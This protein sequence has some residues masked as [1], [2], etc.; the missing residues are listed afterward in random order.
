MP[1]IDDAMAPR[2]A[3]LTPWPWRLLALGLAAVA[4]LP[5]RHEFPPITDFAEH[6]ATIATLEDLWRH[7]PLE[8]WYQ[9]DFVHTQYWLM[10]VLGA[11]LAP[12][13]GGASAAL[14]LLMVAASAGLVASLLRLARNL[15][16]DERLVLVAVPL[17]WS[18]P[19]TLGFVPFVMA[20]PLVVLAL[21]ELASAPRPSTRQHGLIAVLSLATFFLN[22]ASVAWL[23]VAA[24][25]M[26]A[27]REVT[28]STWRSS[29]RPLLNR[30]AGV[31]VLLPLVGAWLAF[32]SVATVDTSRFAVSMK[33]QWWS[34]LHLLRDAPT[35]LMDRWKGE[36]DVWLL[37]VL[38]V[39]VA[40]LL[41]PLG[42]REPSPGRRVAVALWLAT[43]SLTLVL[44]F[45]RGWLWGLS[46]R[47]LPVTVML[48]PLAFSRRRGLVR[49][50]VIA[51]FVGVG[52][53][54]AWGVERHVAAAQ[55]E[56]EGVSVLH[57]LPPGRLLQLTFDD[58]SSVLEDSTVSHASAWHRV[59]NHGANEPSFVD[60]PQSVLRY[61]D[62][63]APW[64]RPWPW[65]FSPLEYDNAREGPHHDFVLTRGAGASFPPSP[66]VAGPKWKLLREAG[67]WRLWAKE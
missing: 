3:A 2:V 22:L 48:A 42:V 39:A 10:A 55:A 11:L 30:V 54:S 13:V 32:S 57:G 8:G 5:L 1:T 7:G 37:A 29:L 56:L 63:K 14:K 49:H 15:G 28:R 40:A 45:E 52:L 19:F 36:L 41:L 12:V 65:E 62:G 4:M 26:S 25:A 18:R 35:W 64:T 6:A 21:A 47:F 59:W 34:P 9:T 46:T 51:S 43:A 61:R 38:L 53:M 60:L 23:L 33:G 17:L 24:V 16:L 27:A 20:A 58:S 44:P 31:V 50:L 66:D 67:A